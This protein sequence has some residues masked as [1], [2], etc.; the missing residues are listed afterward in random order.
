[1]IDLHTHILPAIDD[2]AENKEVAAGQMQCLWAQ[3]V[4]SVV[5]TP[6]FYGRKRSPIQFMEAR[7][8]AF[9]SIKDCIPEGMEVFLGAEVHLRRRWRPSDESV[10]SMAYRGYQV[11]THRTSLHDGMGFGALEPPPRFH[12]GHRIRPRRRARGALFEVRRKPSLLA[13]LSDLG[14]LLQMNTMR[15]RGRRRGSP[16]PP[17][18]GGMSTVSAR[19]PTTWRSA[20]PVTPKRAR[21]SKRRDFPSGSGAS[22]KTCA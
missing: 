8:A 6:H 5:F 16:F 17:S 9:D 18:G 11:F 21:R 19:T 12:R 13:A 22:R 14:C 1:M 2:G 15:S 7:A 10:C 20:L 4:H 3:G